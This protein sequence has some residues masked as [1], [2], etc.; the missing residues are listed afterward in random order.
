MVICD[1]FCIKNTNM[2]KSLL[3]FV[4]KSQFKKLR[5]VFNFS[6]KI[7][8]HKLDVDTFTQVF[9]LLRLLIECI[10]GIVSVL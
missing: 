2:R 9:L 4:F 10:F 8:K 7:L 5:K 3:T 6:T 1:S